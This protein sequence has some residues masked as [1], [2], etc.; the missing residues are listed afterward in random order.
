M[1]RWG[2]EEKRWGRGQADQ[3]RSLE[4]RG[5]ENKRSKVSQ[6][7][8][9]RPRGREELRRLRDQVVQMADLHRKE[10]LGVGRKAQPQG[11]RALWL[12]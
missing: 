8:A 1:G 10:K 3:E 4:P 12:G 5:Q 7:G 2:E 11:W 6:P 9:K